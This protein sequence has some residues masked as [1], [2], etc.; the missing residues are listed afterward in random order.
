MK[1]LDALAAACRSIPDDVH[2]VVSRNGHVKYRYCGYCGQLFGHETGGI[3]Y[4]QGI[5]ESF[6]VRTAVTGHA[7]DCTI[8]LRDDAL[9][10][11]DR[12]QVASGNQQ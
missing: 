2:T 1:T 4:Y 5:L 8:A 9:L 11:L 10:M 3:V 12:Q 7:P 6:D